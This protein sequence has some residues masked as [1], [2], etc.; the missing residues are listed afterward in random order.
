MN[1]YTPITT[2]DFVIATLKKCWAPGKKLLEIGCGPAFLRT[3]FQNDY[4]GV[5]ITDEPYR[6]DIPRRPD[7]ICAAEKIPLSDETF[8]IITIKSALYLFTNPDASLQEACRLL[9]PKGKLVVFDY[10]RR[11]QKDL[12]RREG[13]HNRYPCWT[14]WGL[15]NH[16]KAAGFSHTTLLCPKV[17]Q[18][19][20]LP[21]WLY[22][23]AQECLGT[24]AVVMGIKESG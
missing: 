10:N 7:I 18:P 19:K 6:P 8:D 17:I 23:L 13:N 2:P 9:R 14:Q 20:N 11:T 3:E 12:Q 4:L 1:N 21:R 15:K 22:L 5:D 16:I 24:W